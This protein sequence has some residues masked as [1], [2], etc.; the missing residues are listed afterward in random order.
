MAA[1]VNAALSDETAMP[2]GGVLPMPVPPGETT[3]TLESK[4]A[5][6]RGRLLTAETQSSGYGDRDNAPREDYG[7][8]RI[9][10]TP[11]EA[12]V[13]L[14][15]DADKLLLAACGI[16]TE[17]VDGGDGSALREAYRRLLFSTI[18]PLGA[19]VQHELRMKL[20]TPALRLEWQELRAA[21]IATRARAFKGLVE[22]GMDMSAAA[23]NSGIL[24][25]G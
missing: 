12:L 6:L 20:D 23:A 9:G 16:P 14:R 3:S 11:Q 18:Q 4:I 19:L 1:N 2:R 25:E 8:K 5:R 17:L 22:S 10:A 7:V 21:D 13:R 15:A 24:A